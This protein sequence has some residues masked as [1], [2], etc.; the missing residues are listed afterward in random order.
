[1][2]TDIPLI[3]IGQPTGLEP[4]E[5][6][7]V[8]CLLVQ[9][10]NLSVEILTWFE[11]E[12]LQRAPA[13]ANIPPIEAYARPTPSRETS[14]RVSD[15]LAI[16]QRKVL[17]VSGLCNR[18]VDRIISP[19]VQALCSSKGCR[20]PL[21]TLRSQRRVLDPGRPR[22]SNRSGEGPSGNSAKDRGRTSPDTGHD[23]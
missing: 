2:N 12:V 5:N 11:R 4:R 21:P 17:R 13:W 23:S 15:R 10:H 9:F 1:M 19:H 16:A 20:C 3:S 22:C 8:C 18:L 7:S 6:A 14:K